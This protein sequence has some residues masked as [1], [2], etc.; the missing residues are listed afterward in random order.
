MS[1][2]D[3]GLCRIARNWGLST[4]VII[5]ELA[6]RWNIWRLICFFN[7]IKIKQA[8]FWWHFSL[9]SN[10]TKVMFIIF[11][12]M[13]RSWNTIIVLVIFFSSSLVSNNAAPASKPTGK[14]LKLKIWSHKRTRAKPLTHSV[15]CKKSYLL[16]KVQAVFALYPTRINTNAG[17]VG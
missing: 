4:G 5:L 13:T 2:S 10:Y 14:L 8:A 12:Q 9:I 16:R 6:C 15:Q 1:I 3:C 11:L 7:K 17:V